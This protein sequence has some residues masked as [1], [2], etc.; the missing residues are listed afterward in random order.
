MSKSWFHRSV[1]F[2]LVCWTGLSAEDSSCGDAAKSCRVTVRHIEGKGLGYPTGYTTLEG[3]FAPEMRCQ[4]LLPFLDLRGHLFDN[5][6]YA[7]NA[8]LGL[9]GILGKRVYGINAYYDYR[10]SHRHQYQQVAIG[11]ETL[12]KRWD[13]RINGYCPVGSKNSGFYGNGF[14]GFVGNFLL[15]SQKIEFAMRGAD[16]EAGVH[17]GKMK[18]FDFYAA[19]GPYYFSGERGKNAWGGKARIAG[20]Y[21]EC[22][23]LELSNSY[24]GV[25][26]EIFQGQLSLTYRF[27]SNSSKKRDCCTAQMLSERIVQ[28]VARDE[29][30]V[31]NTA[32]RRKI[33]INPATGAPYFFLFVNNQSNSLGTFESPF[34]TLAQAQTASHPGDLIYVYPGDGTS[35]GMNTGFVM[36]NGQELLGASVPVYLQTTDGPITIPPHASTMP[37]ITHPSNVPGTSVI[38]MRNNTTISGLHIDSTM[39]GS[40]TD[41]EVFADTVSNL[42]IINNLITT[43][44]PQWSLYLRYISGNLYFANNV[45]ET[46][47]AQSVGFRL[48]NGTGSV[49]TVSLVNNTFI[50]HTIFATHFDLHGNTIDIISVVGNRYFAGPTSDSAIVYDTYQNSTASAVFMNNSFFNYLD[51][52]FAS[53]TENNGVASALVSNNLFSAG[54]TPASASAGFVAIQSDNSRQTITVTNNQI[55]KTGLF[56][57]H[58]NN[59][60]TS[61]N[62]SFIC[63]NNIV[64]GGGQTPG[65]GGG[66]GVNIAALSG[67]LKASVTNNTLLDN[68]DNGG[69]YALVDAAATG[70]LCLNLQ[71]NSSNTGYTLQNDAASGHFVLQTGSNASNVGIITQLG[72]IVIA[73]CY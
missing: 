47:A 25:F 55:T 8:G 19:A 14:G 54:D 59:S 15:A 69:F 57:I 38:T 73:P 40:N 20:N 50:G 71:D 1:L 53:T 65:L 44:V 17:F 11:A 70:N 62:G 42:T 4:P 43:S 36:Q 34:P 5:G 22:L 67:N 16:A 29:I 28:P 18:N 64:S 41:G 7:A 58:F 46:T 33:A 39:V 2:S 27:G 37:L 31:L 13:A 30:I 66:I 72:P 24:D 61:N 3:F 32:K 51:I 26:G 45:V 6:K 48:D 63:S 21:R 35:T 60:S 12:G 49:A 68:L 52:A 56:G 10:Q 9:R 23:G